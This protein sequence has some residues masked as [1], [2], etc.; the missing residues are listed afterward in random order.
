M[1]AAMLTIVMIL[2]LATAVGGQSPSEEQVAF[3]V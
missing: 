1:R 3:E 2:G